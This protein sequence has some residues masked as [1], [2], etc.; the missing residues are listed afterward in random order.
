M[1]ISK[2]LV[3][4]LA[5]LAIAMPATVDAKAKRGG[6]K[7]A[8]VAKVKRGGANANRVQGAAQTPA[9][10]TQTGQGA[11][12]GQTNSPP[13]TPPTSGP[14]GVTGEVFEGTGI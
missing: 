1:R 7:P 9:Q 3:A 14:N 12:P 4:M 8:G 10:T 11:Q 13:Q 5:T 2:T 6:A